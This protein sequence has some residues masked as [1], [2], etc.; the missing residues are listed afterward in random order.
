MVVWIRLGLEFLPQKAPKAPVPGQFPSCSL[1]GTPSPVLQLW[2]EGLVTSEHRVSQHHVGGTGVMGA[3]ACTPSRPCFSVTCSVFSL[4]RFYA[5]WW[6]PRK[7]VPLH[8]G[9]PSS[10]HLPE[11]SHSAD[12]NSTPTMGLVLLWALR[13]Q[14]WWNKIYWWAGYN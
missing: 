12:L 11:T 9:L 8:K 10:S 4:H 5:S 6:R 7:S 2:C 13:I 14:T 1:A 3:P